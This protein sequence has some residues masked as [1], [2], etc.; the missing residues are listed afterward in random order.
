MQ[1]WWMFGVSVLFRMSSSS[2]A[3]GR[4]GR[5]KSGLQHHQSRV[6]WACKAASDKWKRK[7]IFFL[8]LLF[9]W[10]GL[11]SKAPRPHPIHLHAVHSK[12]VPREDAGSTSRASN[13]YGK[14]LTG[15]LCF[16]AACAILFCWFPWRCFSDVVTACTF[17]CCGFPAASRER[18]V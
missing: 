9:S 8:L 7:L 12:L 13:I 2:E 17:V 5:L 16:L 14:L 3:A 1:L 10:K 6:L 11:D 4:N 15:A 18:R